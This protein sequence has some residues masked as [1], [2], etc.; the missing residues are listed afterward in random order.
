MNV[1]GHTHDASHNDT[2]SGVPVFNPGPLFKGRYGIY[3]LRKLDDRW[4]LDSYK[5]LSV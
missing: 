4:M 2:V 5:F 1:H 3:T